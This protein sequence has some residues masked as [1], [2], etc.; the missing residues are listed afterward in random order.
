MHQAR[1]LHAIRNDMI[2]FF[3]DTGFSG[4]EFE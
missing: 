2:P 1:Y 4:Q 3:D